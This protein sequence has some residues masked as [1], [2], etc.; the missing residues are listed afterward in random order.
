MI[1]LVATLLMAAPAPVKVALPA[2]RLTDL[3]AERAGFYT[4]QVGAE[5]LARGLRV[6]SE[7]DISSMLGL[8]RQRELLGCNEGSGACLVELANALGVDGIVLGDVARV[9]SRYQ[10]SLRV[11]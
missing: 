3:P 11:I 5:L 9:G 8:E 4:E 6:V 1:A 7:R 2:L 10:A